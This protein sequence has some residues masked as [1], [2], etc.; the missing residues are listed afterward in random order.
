MSLVVA[1]IA[2]HKSA[3][4]V[5]FA[6]D[7]RIS[8][9]DASRWDNAQKVFASPGTQEIFAFAGDVIFPTQTLSQ[10]CQIA[11]TGA[12]FDQHALA[13][14]R[15]EIYCRILRSALD[16]YPKHCLA[17]PFDVLYAHCS[18]GEFALFRIEYAPKGGVSLIREKI[19]ERSAPLRVLGSGQKLFD[20]QYKREPQTSWGIFHALGKVI[21]AKL[22]KKVGGIPQMVSLYSDGRTNLYGLSYFGSKGLLGLDASGAACPTAVEWR[23]ENFERWDPK[24]NDLIAGAQRQPRFDT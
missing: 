19:L 17:E 10:L 2:T 20:N 16:S 13:E 11:P 22:D 23:N 9:N 21:D 4:S 12:L 5:Y 18:K 7:S 8:W 15:A 1:W 3:A 24:T 14:D 6:S